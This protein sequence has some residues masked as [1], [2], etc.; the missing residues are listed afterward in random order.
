MSV[1]DMMEDLIKQAHELKVGFANLFLESFQENGH[2][3]CTALDMCT[4]VMACNMMIAD[5]IAALVTPESFR[6]MGQDRSISNELSQGIFDKMTKFTTDLLVNAGVD[7][8][9]L[10]QTQN[11]EN[12]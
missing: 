7:K 3:L 4:C 6:E 10:M 11:H 1:E 8:Q 9:A 5:C 2:E 12:N